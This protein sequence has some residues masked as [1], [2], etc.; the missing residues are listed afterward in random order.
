MPATYRE[1]AAEVV[2]R[3]RND[4]A[5][6]AWQL[7]NEAEDK[8]DYTGGCSST[9][10]A[11]LKAFAADMSSLVKS[12]DPN[13]L[14]SLG[15]IG[16]GQCGAAGAAY[17]DVHSV[18]RI[19]LCEFHD[20]TQAAMPGDQWNGLALR[21]LQCAGLGKPLF[22]GEVGIKTSLVDSLLGRATLLDAK[23]SVQLAAGVVGILAWDWRDGAHGG[24]SLTGYE[25]GP[26]D[27]SLGVLGRH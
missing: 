11:T 2:S 6:L 19:D 10:T 26:S 20:Y 7:V 13:H 8:V 23:L 15:T 16:S 12:L 4:P 5:I 27:P 9:A 17:Q 18:P 22:V 3:Y 1:W 25:I 14:V 24:S 21:L